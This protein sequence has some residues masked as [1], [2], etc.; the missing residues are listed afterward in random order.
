MAKSII[1][2]YIRICSLPTGVKEESGKGESLF[3]FLFIVFLSFIAIF[4]LYHTRKLDHRQEGGG[5]VQCILYK[6]CFQFRLRR[7]Q[8]SGEIT[9]LGGGELQTTWILG[10]GDE[11][12]TN[13]R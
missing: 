12:I 2:L 4:V 5:D 9:L 3:P 7:M 8:Y 10:S 13:R 6:C 11:Q 1:S